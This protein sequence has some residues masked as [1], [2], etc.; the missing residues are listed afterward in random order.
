[1]KILYSLLLIQLLAVYATAQ[2]QLKEMGGFNQIIDL[3]SLQGTQFRLSA[4]AKIESGNVNS[5]WARLFATV[6]TSEGP[7][8]NKY[9]QIT[10][11]EWTEYLIEGPVDPNSKQLVFGGY[12]F[13][14]GKYYFD[15]FNLEVRNQNGEW[16][17]VY[18][19]NSSFEDESLDNKGSV[20]RIFNK[21]LFGRRNGFEQNLST[22]DPVDGNHALLADGSSKTK[23]GHFSAINGVKI[24]YEFHGHGSDTILLLHGNGQSIKSFSEQIPDFSSQFRILAMDSRAQG[25]S[26]DDGNE[27]TYE[28]MAEDVSALL[29]T[30][31]IKRINILGWSDGGNVGLILAM[32]RPS[33]VKQ[34]AT[35]GANLFCDTTSVD[36]EVI[37]KLKQTKNKLE[38]ENIPSAN[39]QLRM[40]HLL[41]NEPKIDPDDLKVISCKTLIM[42]GTRDIIK[43]QHT[44]MIAENIMNSKLVIFKDGTHFEP[45]QNPKRFNKTVISFF[46]SG[47][48]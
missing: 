19:A 44:R 20:D 17:E 13:G 6:S 37:Q 14:I 32:K 18:I 35:M 36:E 22:S 41:L 26:S 45:Q 12:Y 43:Q 3:S 34:L 15:K 39:I 1:M 25:Y 30:L 24:Y 47:S 27:V 8:L 4:Y 10:S 40:I 23:A 5:S 28:L 21:W 33:K 2:E 16:G 7:I 11:N 46:K 29:D 31:K 48:N 9:E 38:S 42:T